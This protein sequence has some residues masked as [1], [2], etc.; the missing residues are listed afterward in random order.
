MAFLDNSGDIILDAVLTDT[1][2]MRMAKGD[3]SFKIVKFALGDDEINYSLYNKDHASGSAYYE[4]E[5]L[6]TPILEAFTDNAASMKS[7][8][9]SIPRT[10]LL[11]L[12]VIMRNTT[13]GLPDATTNNMLTV[14]V[15]ETTVDD[16]DI[17]TSGNEAFIDGKN[18]GYTSKPVTFDQ[19]IQ[20][21]AIGNGTDVPL[22]ADLV[23]TQYIIE[24]D[25]RLGYLTDETGTQA[26]PSFIDDDNIASYYLSTT[27]NT[28]FFGDSGTNMSGDVIKGPRGTRLKFLI[29]PSKNLASS[30]YLFG[31]IGGSSTFG[32]AVNHI[33]STIRIT[34]ATTGY[35]VDLPIRFIKKA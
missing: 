20:S 23:E 12:P 2:R 7:R 30:T 25:S 15:D 33:D 26:T 4:L 11:Y 22:D 9:I 28:A 18:L 27:T 16:T 5:V 1:G 31:Q 14:L 34:G 24:V 19:G 29:A 13:V 17:N 32:V 35:R 10:N 3:G 8:L 6:Q 21:N